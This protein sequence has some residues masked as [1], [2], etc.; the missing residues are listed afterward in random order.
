MNKLISKFKKALLDLT[1]ANVS[2]F[3]FTFFHKAHQPEYIYAKAINR[4]NSSEEHVLKVEKLNL[5]TYSQLVSCCISN[6]V[7]YN[8]NALQ[9]INTQYELSLLESDVVPQ[10]VEGDSFELTAIAESP[11]YYGTLKCSIRCPK[12]DLIGYFDNQTEIKYKAPNG[13]ETKHLLRHL[14]FTYMDDFLASLEA[15]KGIDTRTLDL[16]L[17]RLPH[18]NVNDL[19]CENNLRG[20][21]VI[22]NEPMERS[23]T[24]AN[25]LLRLG[26]NKKLCTNL[27]GVLEIYY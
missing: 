19:P 8:V 17:R 22:S 25:R 13:L 1:S 24:K 27:R 20:S 15:G 4:Y 12:Q 3:E 26:L 16:M 18:F 10:R 14:T 6:R 11:F 5:T 21:V 7:V 9:E 2:D 23:F